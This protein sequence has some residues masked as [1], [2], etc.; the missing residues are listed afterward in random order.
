MDLYLA[1]KPGFREYPFASQV[2]QKPKT[3]NALK[4]AYLL[5]CLAERESAEIHS[6]NSIFNTKPIKQPIKNKLLKGG[7]LN[8]DIKPV[9]TT[10]PKFH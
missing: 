3:K 8:E 10:H 4:R 9:V 5:F 2:S 6:V 1:T 7:L